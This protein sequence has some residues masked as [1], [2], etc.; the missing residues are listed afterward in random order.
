M[1]RGGRGGSTNG[2]QPFQPRMQPFQPQQA[3][4]HNGGMVQQRGRQQALPYSNMVK[5]HNN[6]N[7]CASCGF[8]VED[9][10]T[11]ATC[12]YAW[13]RHDHQEGVN[14]NNWSQYEAQ[15]YNLSRKGM[16]KNQLPSM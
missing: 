16:H 8:D 9:W 12:P 7:V 13:R 15:G 3:T 11:S 6:W 2:M 10:H 4:M 5:R 14:R 1:G